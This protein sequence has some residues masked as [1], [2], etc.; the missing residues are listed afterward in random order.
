MG[1]LANFSGALL[2]SQVLCSHNQITTQVLSQETASNPTV[3]GFVFQVR[4][5]CSAQVSVAFPH[6]TGSLLQSIGPHLYTVLYKPKCCAL[7]WGST[8]SQLPVL[9]TKAS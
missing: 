6:H 9:N 1:A 4:A 5:A 2:Y 3:R 7:H 8:P